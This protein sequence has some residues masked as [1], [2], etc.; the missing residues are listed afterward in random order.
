MRLTLDEISFIGCQSVLIEPPLLSFISAGL[1]NLEGIKLLLR[2]GATVNDRDSHGNTCL[3]QCLRRPTCS[4]YNHNA[5]DIRDCV[6][7]LIQQ[8][9]DVSAKNNH[10]ESVSDIAHQIHESR[11]M[12]THEFQVYGDDA[13]VPV[14]V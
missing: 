5:S 6:M 11:T 2:R 14:Q 3:H 9:A 12:F 10:G 7:Y 4:L 1:F 13:R 8:G